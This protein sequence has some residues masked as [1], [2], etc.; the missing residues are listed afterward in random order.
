MVLVLPFFDRKVNLMLNSQVIGYESL[1][2]D[3]CKL[4]SAS[5]NLLLSLIVESYVAKRFKI[6]KN[7]LCYGMSAQ[8]IFPRKNSR[9]IEKK[10]ITYLP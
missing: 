8:V 2:N 3:L 6:E 9:G 7:L 1:R 5:D 4:S 10:Q